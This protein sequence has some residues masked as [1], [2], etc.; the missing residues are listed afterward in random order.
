MGVSKTYLAEITDESNQSKGFSVLGLN[1]ALGLIIG[2]IIGGFLAIP[3]KKFPDSFPKG[4]FFDV[5]PYALPTVVVFAF[6]LLGVV[7]GYILLEETDVFNKTRMDESADSPNQ[8]INIESDEEDE[9]Q[10][11]L[12]QSMT[13]TIMTLDEKSTVWDLLADPAIF[14]SIMIYFMIQ[15]YYIAYDETFS[16]WARL[17][18]SKVIFKFLFG[19]CVE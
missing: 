3:S 15:C 11:L 8:I 17:D 13:S 14:A 9:T 5:Y 7:L 18:V 10:P 2:P 6:S 12:Q 19:N 1:R 16:L 4:S